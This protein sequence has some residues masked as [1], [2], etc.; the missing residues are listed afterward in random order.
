MCG[1][2]VGKRGCGAALHARPLQCRGLVAG[3]RRAR[4]TDGVGPRGHLCCLCC[5]QLTSD[6]QHFSL[7]SLLGFP[8]C[9]ARLRNRLELACAASRRR[10]PL[11]LEPGPAHEACSDEKFP[12]ACAV[13]FAP[14]E[15]GQLVAGA[16][17]GGRG[18]WSAMCRGNARSKSSGLRRSGERGGAVLAAPASRRRHAR[19][20]PQPVVSAGPLHV[21][22]LTLPPVR[23]TS[24]LILPALPYRFP[25]SIVP[26]PQRTAP[27]LP[28]HLHTRRPTAPPLLPVPRPR[29]PSP[30]PPF[31]L[32]L[33]FD[34]PP[35]VTGGRWRRL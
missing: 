31:P 12:E 20:L 34:G 30:S 24:H 18:G 5:S 33:V 22:V 7:H 28:P 19:N 15:V 13:L 1:A 29:I 23:S 16:L 17:P 2:G 8:A 9:R 27:K 25:A 32:C 3:H 10:L 4:A 11:P 14:R 6:A 35:A 26:P 21:L